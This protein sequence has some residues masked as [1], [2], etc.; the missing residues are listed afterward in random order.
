MPASELFP[1][2]YQKLTILVSQVAWAYHPGLCLLSQGQTDHHDSASAKQA[3]LPDL[4]VFGEEV[5]GFCNCV[6]FIGSFGD[7]VSCSKTL[8]LGF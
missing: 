1:S 2:S 4:A 7:G 3:R 5:S 6:H 8:F